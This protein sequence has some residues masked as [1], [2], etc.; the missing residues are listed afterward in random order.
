MRI[1]VNSLLSRILFED[2][3]IEAN[4]RIVLCA[5]NDLDWVAADFAVFDIDLAANRKVQNH[6]NLFPTIGAVKEVFH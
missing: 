4:E 3:C 2:L 1:I 5:V 6:R